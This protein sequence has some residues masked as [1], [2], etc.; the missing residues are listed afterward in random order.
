MRLLVTGCCGFIGSNFVRMIAR[1]DLKEL[2]S[3][4]V[5]DKL[6]NAGVRS[7]LAEADNLN[8]YKFV[9]GDIC[10]SKLVKSLLNEVDA[11]I[12]FA[13]ESH[14]DRSIVG[15]DDFVQTNIVGVQVLLEAIK[16]SGRK[17]RFL[18]V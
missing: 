5:L 15:A 18:Q 10:D 16:A 12:N 11:V 13:A 1:E 14:V 2:T 17:L 6:T 7:N 3:V 4:T 8:T 9:K